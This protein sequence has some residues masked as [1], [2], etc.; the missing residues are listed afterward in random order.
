MTSP[1]PNHLPKAPPPDIITLGVKISTYTLGGGQ[2]R[3]CSD[4]QSVALVST[5]PLRG[6]ATYTSKCVVAPGTCESNLISRWRQFSEV[7]SWPSGDVKQ[8]VNRDDHRT[9]VGMKGNEDT[10]LT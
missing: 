10:I 5:L 6:K 4:I 7:R 3:R 9:F 2:H 8:E 1:K